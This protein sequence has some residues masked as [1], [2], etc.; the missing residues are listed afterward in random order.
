[1]TGAQRGGLI[2]SIVL[3]VI[4]GSAV[5]AGLGYGVTVEGG[6]IG[7]G[8]LPVLAGGLVAVFAVLDIVGRLRPRR[9]LP[10]Q[11]ELILDTVD[12]PPAGVAGYLAEQNAADPG[13]VSTSTQTIHREAEGDEVDIF[14]RTQSQRN[15][16]L[17]IV[18]GIVVLTL[19]A[20]QLVGFLIAFVL[21][22]VVIAVFVERRSLVPSVVVALVAGGVT[23][24]IF[25]ALLR[26]PLPQGLLGLI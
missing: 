23:Y 11:A 3:A 10:S 2:A 5:S 16:M 15:R 26:V 24:A 4:G 9:A 18:L 25:V 17:G 1:M 20:V 19:L 12:A 7:P 6:E 13:A 21:M 14:G 8:F 22:L